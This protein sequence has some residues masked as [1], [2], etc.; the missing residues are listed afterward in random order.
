MILSIYLIAIIYLT[1]EIGGLRVCSL[2]QQYYKDRFFPSLF[3]KAL[4]FFFMPVATWSQDSCHSSKYHVFT[5]SVA[6]RK[7]QAQA[8]VL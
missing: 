5:L 7:G 6:S 8:K 4:S 1:G 3:S 2:A